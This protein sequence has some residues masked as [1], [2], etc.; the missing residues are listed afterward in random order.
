MNAA[1]GTRRL[2]AFLLLV[3]WTPLVVAQGN[4]PPDPGMRRFNDVP[5]VTALTGDAACAFAFRCFT[6]ASALEGDTAVVGTTNSSLAIYT[7]ASNGW[8]LQ[9]V[10]FDPD[11][12]PN[13]FFVSNGFGGSVGLSGDTLITNLESSFPL[14]VFKRQSGIWSRTQL[15]PGKVV[16][17]RSAF[18]TDMALDGDTALVN[19]F[20]SYEPGTQGPAGAVLVFGR[21]RNGR[22]AQEAEILPNRNQPQEGFN[23]DV[24]LQ[25]RTA[26]VSSFTANNGR[27]AVYVYR[28]LGRFW[29]LTQTLTAPDGVP[30][31][32]FGVSVEI[33]GRR[34]VVGASEQPNAEAP[35]RPGALYT[36]VRGPLRWRLRDKLVA[37]FEFRS[38]DGSSTDIEREYNFAT[39][40]ALSG[41]RLVV[42]LS[43][44]GN[45]SPFD[46]FGALLYER[47]SRS[48][49]WIE[50]GQ[51][52][53]D[54]NTLDLFARFVDG[55]TAFLSTS[56][57]PFGGFAAIY[58]LPPL[59]PIPANA[60]PG[61]KRAAND[62]DEESI[63]EDGIADEEQ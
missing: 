36:F 61:A 47:D 31:S 24:E 43:N 11:F 32:Q 29:L 17:G 6:G 27:G 60:S 20:Y 42:S 50:T 5:L 26:L 18:V 19:V 63:D 52:S 2:F 59:S 30:G 12:P 37:P 3:I 46:I 53:K 35:A 57:V 40:L 44:R 49:R 7:R 39:S 45:T 8:T 1:S 15:I 54:E 23:F 34:I 14:E 62:G 58:E 9:Q 33:S 22:F 56:S 13:P 38:G 10:L 55:Q 16:A 41:S 25:G 4:P 51:L 21:Q 48:G 28:K